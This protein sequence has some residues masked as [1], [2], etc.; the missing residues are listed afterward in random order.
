MR[1][2]LSVYGNW[3]TFF[4]VNQVNNSHCGEEDS[5]S[6]LSFSLSQAD[7]LWYPLLFCTQCSGGQHLSPA[8]FCSGRDRHGLMFGALS[9][10]GS[11]RQTR[12]PPHLHDYHSTGLV[13]AA[14]P[15]QL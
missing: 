6:D 13:T 8:L 3:S 11:I 12:R 2:L 5:N 14:R 1:D 9:C 10:G 4:H 7:W 15:A